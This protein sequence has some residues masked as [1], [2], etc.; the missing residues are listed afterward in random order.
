[1]IK[2]FLKAFG[3]TILLGFFAWIPNIIRFEQ[4]CPGIDHHPGC[5]GGAQPEVFLLSILGAPVIGIAWALYK[6]RKG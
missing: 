1:M 3:L 5:M 2:N 6:R 4:R